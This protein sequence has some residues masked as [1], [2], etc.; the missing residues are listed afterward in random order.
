MGLRW[1]KN[2]CV[3]GRIG[4]LDG[5]LQVSSDRLRDTT[6]PGGAASPIRNIPHH[7]EVCQT[8][9]S[10]ALQTSTREGFVEDCLGVSDRRALRDRRTC[11]RTT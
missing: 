6:Q 7:P 1:A 11:P 2:L 9:A 10:K 5:R 8:H 4:H 3:G